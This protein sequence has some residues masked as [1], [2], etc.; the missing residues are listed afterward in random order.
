MNRTSVVLRLAAVAALVAA[1]LAVQ[2]II[3]NGGGV[4]SSLLA[5]SPAE[6]EEAQVRVAAQR[7]ASGRVELAVQVE[8]QGQWQPRVLPET[9]WLSSRSRVDRWI[10]TTPVSLS[11]GHEVR[12][13]A[14]RLSSGEVELGLQEILDGKRQER[15]LPNDRLL[16]ADHAASEWWTSSPLILPARLSEPTHV[17]LVRDWTWVNPTLTYNTHFDPNGTITTWT[18]TQPTTGGEWATADFAGV[19]RIGCYSSDNFNIQIQGIAPLEADSIAVTLTIDDLTFPAQTWDVWTHYE[20]DEAVNSNINTPDPR[21]LFRLL[22]GAKQLSAEIEG[23]E[24]TRAWDLSRTMTTPI[25]ANFE[26]CANYVVGYIQPQPLPDY[27]PLVN[28]NGWLGNVRYQSGTGDDGRA[29][30]DT[31]TYTDD[32]E[33]LFLKIGTSDHGEHFFVLVDQLPPLDVDEVAVVWSIDDGD[34]VEEQWWVQTFEDSHS[35]VSPH[36]RPGFYDQLRDASSFTFEVEEADTGSITFDLTHT[37]AT[38][39]QLNIDERGNWVVGQSRE[40]VYDYVPLTNAQGREAGGLEWRAQTEEDG[41]VSTYVARTID[42]DEV[43]ASLRLY[44]SCGSWGGM[45]VKVNGV[46]TPTDGTNS[47]VVTLQIEDGEAF[48]QTWDLAVYDEFATVFARRDAQLYELLRGAS[49]LTIEVADSSLPATTFDLTG[50]FDTPVQDNI[51]NCGMYR[52]GETREIEYDYVP[53]VNVRGQTA[54]SADY[55]SILNDDGTVYTY[56]THAFSQPD[57]ALAQFS[58]SCDSSSLETSVSLGG[59]PLIE[60]DQID[61]DHSDRRRSGRDGDLALLRLRA[62]ASGVAERLRCIPPV[63]T[64]RDHDHVYC[65]RTRLRPHHV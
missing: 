24:G 37:F 28:V 38:P 61:C 52:A 51:D 19:L 58:M 31:L 27:V 35:F 45:D 65:E 62:M 64:R 14:R 47:A 15:Q 8:T 57:G 53:V 43:S 44:L 42:V 3:S 55:G 1:A 63:A 59:L 2:N 39:V 29:W 25:Q 49:S 6:A 30:S 16:P 50:M 34:S 13:S 23:F 26:H 5:Q 33:D 32:H 4:S 56:V 17:P 20:N 40:P 12:I 11:S 48:T 21:R 9:R 54:G 18:G 7:L 46:P 22:R 10:S 60:G 36:D 41:R